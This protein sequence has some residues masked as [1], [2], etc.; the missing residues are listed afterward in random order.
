MSH[1]FATPSAAPRSRPPA[2]PASA[3]ASATPSTATSFAAAAAAGAAAGVSTTP[4]ASLFQTPV[5]APAGAAP[6]PPA[7]VRDRLRKRKRRVAAAIDRPGGFQLDAIDLT[8][9]EEEEPDDDPVESFRAGIAGI[10]RGG[11][12]MN[13][14]A[15]RHALGD[16]HHRRPSSSSSSSRAR[17][18]DAAGGGG[19][20]DPGWKSASSSDAKSSG[21][22]YSSSVNGS[23]PTGPF[24]GRGKPPSPPPVHPSGPTRLVA[25]LRQL[26][27]GCVKRHHAAAALFYADKLITISPGFAQD[28]LLFADACYLNH[29]YHRAIHA[30]KKAKLAEI[31]NVNVIRTLTLRAYLLLGQC[32]LAIKQKEECLELLG[33]VLPEEETAVVAFARRYER[34]SED[35]EDAGGLNVVSALA[36]LMGETFE[37]VG[38]RENAATYFR[39]A[40]RCDVYNSEAFFHL[41]DKQMLTAQDEKRLVASLNYSA[42]E[43]GLLR[44]LYQTHV[45]KYDPTP[46]VNEKFNDIE[47]KFGMKDNLDL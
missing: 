39:I 4:Q 32:M 38:N 20:S 19:D 42:D 24:R 46:T 11:A 37:A 34:E 35:P 29:E 44:L 13:V 47:E 43:M 14:S 7:V 2:T 31:D 22:R 30:V 8:I 28:V 16:H 18:A 45:G 21:L 40:L 33:K 41:F 26:V 3:R 1:P 23:T 12:A 17:A 15:P 6:P 10:A 25:K 9:D 36:L 5:G 27:R